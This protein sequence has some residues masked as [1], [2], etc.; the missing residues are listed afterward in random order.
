MTSRFFAYM[1]SLVKCCLAVSLVFVS[2]FVIG[3]AT[4]VPAQ[5]NSTASADK[6]NA[7]LIIQSGEKRH[8]FSIEI[9][10]DDATRAKGLMYRTKIAPDHG[11]LFDFE[12]TEQ[13]YMWMKNT[14]ISLDM[15]FVSADGTISHIVKNTTPLSQ[16]IISSGGPV[17][18]V[19]EVKAGTADR[20]A[21]SRGDRL[22][23]QLFTPSK[24]K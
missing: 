17:R 21:L 8:S 23:H 24:A 5:T 12:K 15:L 1:V 7:T 16:S 13:V 20:L 18:Y 22:L 2:L 4:S 19:L 6:M 14:Y 3:S 11:M 9:A 10:D